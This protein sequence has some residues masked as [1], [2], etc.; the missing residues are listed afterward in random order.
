MDERRKEENGNA[1]MCIQFPFV[2]HAD[3]GVKLT[4]DIYAFNGHKCAHAVHFIVE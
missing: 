1:I 2:G 4:S 3:D